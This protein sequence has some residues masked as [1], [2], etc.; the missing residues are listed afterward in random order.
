MNK[1]LKLCCKLGLKD[2]YWSL[3]HKVSKLLAKYFPYQ[4]ALPGLGS[5]RWQY[6][7]PREEMLHAM[8]QAVVNQVEDPWFGHI[9]W[10]SDPHHWN[11]Y[12]KTMKVYNWYRRRRPA[13]YS[14]LDFYK[15][16]EEFPMFTKTEDG[17]YKMNFSEDPEWDKVCE[18]ES[19]YEKMYNEEDQEMLKEILEVR[20]GLWT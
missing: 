5:H 15:M 13:R 8:A 6:C 17:L 4:M 2:L 18:L 16:P 1:L 14:P 20:L 11:T 10:E 12:C 19:I 7:D 9:D 3:N